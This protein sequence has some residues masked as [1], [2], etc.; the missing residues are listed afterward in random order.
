MQ[1]PEI[2]MMADVMFGEIAFPPVRL[3]CAVI[4]IID[5]EEIRLPRGQGKGFVESMFGQIDV[6]VKDII[7]TE[8]VLLIDRYFELGTRITAKVGIAAFAY[9]KPF[10]AHEIPDVIK[11]VGASMLQLRHCRGQELYAL[12]LA[13]SR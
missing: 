5:E 12:D 1:V 4:E 10:V 2:H 3:C 7:R 8:I 13:S 6:S 9:F 11:A